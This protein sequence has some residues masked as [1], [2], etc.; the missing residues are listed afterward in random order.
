MEGRKGVC[1]GVR[2]LYLTHT[3]THTHTHTQVQHERQF[4]KYHLGRGVKTPRGLSPL[5]RSHFEHL[6]GILSQNPKS[7]VIAKVPCP[8]QQTEYNLETQNLSTLVH[9]RWMDNFAMDCLT[10]DMNRRLLR[11]GQVFLPT[12][13]QTLVEIHADND[14]SDMVRGAVTAV[15]KAQGRTR[16]NVAIM[17]VFIPWLQ[18]ECHWAMG[19]VSFERGRL[20]YFDSLQ[21]SPSDSTRNSLERAAREFRANLPRSYPSCGG[22]VVNRSREWNGGYKQGYVKGRAVITSGSCGS[23][24]LQ[25]AYTI[26]TGRSLNW[27]YEDMP[28]YRLN[29]MLSLVGRSY[30]TKSTV[31]ST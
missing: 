15:M 5:G 25:A 28:Y 7:R 1:G 18:G 20:E 21:Y 12:M 30:L 17:N 26:A 13:F 4:F 14:I 29:Q 27:G 8:L 3:H 19:V 31:I 22:R 11:K 6:Y 10:A 24:A 9:E 23:V 2:L 16:S